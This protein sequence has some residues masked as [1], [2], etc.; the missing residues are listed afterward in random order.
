MTGRLATP[1]KS[2]KSQEKGWTQV[3]P[4]PI[5]HHWLDGHL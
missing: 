5:L 4:N 2:L 3:G 1:E